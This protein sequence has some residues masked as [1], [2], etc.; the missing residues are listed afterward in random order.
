[1][2]NQ[3]IARAWSENEF[4]HKLRNC[5]LP[6]ATRFVYETCHGEKELVPLEL[7]YIWKW[8]TDVLDLPMMEWPNVCVLSS[9]EDGPLT[10]TMATNDV[11]QPAK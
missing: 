8:V 4:H 3:Y 7:R 11:G 6:D 2:N 1:M 9:G 10:T 5:W